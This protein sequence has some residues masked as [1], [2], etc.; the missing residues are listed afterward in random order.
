MVS[1]QRGAI[2]ILILT[3]IMILISSC[4]LA[5]PF[6]Q[7][8]AQA[9]ESTPTTVPTLHPTFTPTPEFTATPTQTNTPTNTPFPTATP[10]STITPTPR[11]T[12]TPTPTDTG[13]PT[14]PPPPTN[15]P[16]PT[17]TPEPKWGYQLAELYSQPTEATILSIMVAVQNHDG[18]WSP[19]LRLVGLDPNGV[20]T[21]SEPSADQQTGY[22][23]PGDVIKSGNT[24]FE[25][26]SNYV[27]GT[28]L[29]HLETPDGKQVSETIPLNMDAENREWYFFRFVPD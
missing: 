24:K 20:L 26:L 8:V 28:W 14:P 29:F 17:N 21:K 7:L 23:P 22:T 11:P 19:G 5:S 6:D 16:L 10:T 9:V 15:T 4:T 2:Y 12:Q 27:T 25:P 1:N 13:T 3:L 18:G